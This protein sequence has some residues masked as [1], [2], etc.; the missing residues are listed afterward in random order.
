MNALE[1]YNIRFDVV[2]VSLLDYT[3]ILQYDVFI[4]SCVHLQ[5]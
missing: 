4:L 1:I 5:Q 2:S 3:I